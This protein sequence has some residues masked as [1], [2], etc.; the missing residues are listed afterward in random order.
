MAW[1]LDAS[2]AGSMASTA[3]LVFLLVLAFAPERGLVSRVRQQKRQRQV[4]ARDMLL[5]H[6]YHHEG[7]PEAEQECRVE[8]LQDHLRVKTMTTATLYESTHACMHA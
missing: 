4:F 1:W 2:I 7:L 6:L 8:H 5:I 3:G